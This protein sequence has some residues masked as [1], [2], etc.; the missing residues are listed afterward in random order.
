ELSSRLASAR[1]IALIRNTSA[2]STRY[3]TPAKNTN[4]NSITW[5]QCQVRAPKYAATIT[6]TRRT[7]MPIQTD[8]ALS[9][10]GDSRK[11]P[12]TG[13]EAAAE[14]GRKTADKCPIL[15]DRWAPT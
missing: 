11:N 1:R 2:A 4:T 9:L 12:A 7:R 10:P 14:I 8:N 6:A 5:A 13:A 15:D 3:P